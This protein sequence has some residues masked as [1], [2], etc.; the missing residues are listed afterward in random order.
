MSQLLPFSVTHKSHGRT[1]IP[2]AGILMSSLRILG[3]IL[4]D[5]NAPAYSSSPFLV[6]DTYGTDDGQFQKGILKLQ[7]REVLSIKNGISPGY[8]TYKEVASYAMDH[9]GFA[10]VPTT[11]FVFSDSTTSS[12]SFEPNNDHDHHQVAVLGSVQQYVESKGCSED[13]GASL[14]SV[15]DV[16]SIAVLDMR[17]LNADRHLGNMLLTPDHRLVPIDHGLVLPSYRDLSDVRFEWAPWAQCDQP[18]SAATRLYVA[19]LNPLRDATLLY[20]LGIAEES[21]ISMIFATFLLMRASAKGF[22]VRLVASFMQRDPYQAEQP[23]LIERIIQRVIA[24]NRYLYECADENTLTFYQPFLPNK[25]SLLEDTLRVIDN[26][27]TAY[28]V[29]T[30]AANSEPDALDRLADYACTPSD[31]VRHIINTRE[32]V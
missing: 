23:S 7:E 21:I 20:S 15:D 29:A 13:Y 19:Q 4:Q 14:F 30:D 16:H 8:S 11:V 18:L 10:R 9:D 31:F 5:E 27:L 25:I 28:A 32:I 17:L 3:P 12:S 24:C 1:G 6:E 2:L 22:T 26:E